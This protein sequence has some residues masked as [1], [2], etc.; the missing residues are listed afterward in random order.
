MLT[1]PSLSA[2]VDLSS[3]NVIF[4]LAIGF[5]AMWAMERFKG[6]PL[7]LPVVFML[8]PLLGELIHCDYGG[9][10]VLS[11]LLFYLGRRSGKLPEVWGFLPLLFLGIR[12]KVQPLCIFSLPLLL[13]YNGERGKNLKFFFYAAYPLHL[14]ILLAVKLL[15]Q[16]V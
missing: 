11:I 16:A 12:S 2:L 8:S 9:M 6:D 14:L 1:E 5:A 3:Q 4:T 10:G 7:T 13:L 15:H